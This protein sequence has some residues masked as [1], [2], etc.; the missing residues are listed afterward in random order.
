MTTEADPII[1]Q[2]YHHLDKGQEF[3][4]ISVDETN[5]T[6]ETQHVDG[7]VEEILADEWYEMEVELVATPEDWN[8]PIDEPE[9]EATERMED[10]EDE[11]EWGA[12]VEEDLQETEVWA[13]DE[14]GRDADE[15]GEAY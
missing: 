2:W 8:G 9:Y 10:V 7:N 12:T 15:W 13:G 4:V 11:E 6:I 1:G 3:Q 5:G 14:F